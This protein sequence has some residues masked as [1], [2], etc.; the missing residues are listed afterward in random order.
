[1]SSVVPAAER[2]P[3]RGRPCDVGLTIPGLPNWRSNWAKFW[4]VGPGRAKI[5]LENVATGG[6]L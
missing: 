3:G 5:S 2:R 6:K 1:M 4:K